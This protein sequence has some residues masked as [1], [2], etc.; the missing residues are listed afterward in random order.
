[1]Q[2]LENYE[3]E[4]A[5]CSRCG[6]CQSVCP[7]YKITSNECCVSKG[8]FAMLLGV[9]KGDLK[10][11][12]NINKYL[13][14]CLKCGKCNDFCP[15][16]IN[17]TEIL[18]CAKYNYMKNNL[19][20]KIIFFLQSK[21]VFGNIIR[22]GKH[23]SKIFRKANKTYVNAKKILYFKGCVNEIFPQSDK[24]IHKIFKNVE[25]NIITPDFD[26]CGLPFL[27][28][29]N[30][31]RFE[32]CAKSNMKKM[33]GDYD[34]IVTDCASCQNTLINYSKYFDFPDIGNDK[35]LDWGEIIAQN[36]IKFQFDRP[37]RVTFHKPCHLNKDDFLEEIVKNCENIEY[38]K[39]KDYDDCCGFAGSFALKN[40][41]LSDKLCKSKA[42]NIEATKADYVITTCP[43][44]IL[45]LKRGLKLIKNKNIKV[46]SLLEFLALSKIKE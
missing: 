15:A 35:F 10:L 9:V 41:K 12:K 34:Y 45:G 16:G 40:T 37:T 13:D 7:I 36:S 14:L 38:I 18:T 11:T 4:L 43:S 42:L 30:F 24:Y 6:L 22:I 31:L 46:V 3:K 26:C 21:Y 2:D 17:A 8:K 27:S 20:A 25:L 28:E 23:L 39:M 1:M 5:K 44:C 32:E 29:G 33:N 19:L